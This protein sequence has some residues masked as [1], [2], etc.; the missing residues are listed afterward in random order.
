MKG[1]K[2]E[3]FTDYC[4]EQLGNTRSDVVNM[5]DLLKNLIGQEVVT[6][7]QKEKMLQEIGIM[8]G[9]ATRMKD[10][11]TQMPVTTERKTPAIVEKGGRS[12]E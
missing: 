8:L 5:E 7:E 4:I 1:M 9:A 2:K 3:A 10:S 11:I 12:Y 6:D